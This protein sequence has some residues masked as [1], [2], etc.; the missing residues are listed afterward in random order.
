MSSQEKLALD[1]VIKIIPGVVQGVV[2]NAYEKIQPTNEM[3]GSF[4]EVYQLQQEFLVAVQ[5]AVSNNPKEKFPAI[6]FENRLRQMIN[7]SLKCGQ[8]EKQIIQII[9]DLVGS[10]RAMKHQIR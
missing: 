1:K 4:R 3:Q 7:R 10:I 9:R 6:N 8:E 2:V 5:S